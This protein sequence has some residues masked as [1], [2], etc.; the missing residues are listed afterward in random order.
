ME[1]D[2]LS[3]APRRV[4]AYLD[5]VLA[6]LTRRLSAFHQ[7]ELR[8]ELR[9][10]LW[11]RVS[12]YQELGMSEA[13]AV[14]EALKQFGGAK[15]FLRQWHLE[16]QKMPSQV[17]VREILQAGSAAIKL[18]LTGILAALLPG[19]I[20]HVSYVRWQGDPIGALIS[21]SADIWYPMWTA[22]VLLLLPALIGAKHGRCRPKYAGAGMLVALTAELLMANLLCGIVD[23]FAPSS[24]YLDSYLAGSSDTLLMLTLTW[25]PVACTSAALTGWWTQKHDK[26]KVMA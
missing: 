20:I 24:S 9:T 11:E 16:W 13:D 26:K 12:A 15:D 5:Q 8:R 6:P 23:S 7:Q 19:I 3:S 18:S 14:T 10:H 21:H 25:M 22:G 2:P 4:E 17:P 1:P